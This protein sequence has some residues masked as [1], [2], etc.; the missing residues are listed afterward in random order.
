M[1]IDAEGK[2]KTFHIPGILNSGRINYAGKKLVWDEYVPD[3]RWTNRSFSNIFIYDFE[4]DKHTQISFR[5]RYSSPALSCSGDTVVAVETS[6]NNEFFLVF[7]KND[8]KFLARIPSPGNRQLQDPSWMENTDKIISVG[9][10]KEGKKLMSYDME[11]GKWEIL[12][13]SR[14][15]NISGPVSYSGQIIFHGSFSGID[16]IYSLNLSKNQL[17][18]LTNSRFG[19][20]QPDITDQGTICWSYYTNQG[21]RLTSSNMQEQ[22]KNPFDIPAKITEQPFF[23]YSDIPLPV[24]QQT[25]FS[26]ERGRNDERFNPSRNGI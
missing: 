20:F 7:L 8:G 13:N 12:L 19:A 26:E 17:F 15:V 18:K 2:E 1:K 4:T 24:R 23:S 11:T 9:I 6:L 21:Y 14:N 16:E 22:L 25:L 5:S 3:P 10:D